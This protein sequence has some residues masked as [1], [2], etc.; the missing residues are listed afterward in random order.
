MWLKGVI[1]ESNIVEPEGRPIGSHLHSY[2]I[3]GENNKL[4]FAHLGD[5]KQNE[6][7]LIQNTSYKT[8]ILKI[9]EEVIFFHS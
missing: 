5:I 7:K 3:K 9:G 8:E 4:Y 6:D 1:E 2:I